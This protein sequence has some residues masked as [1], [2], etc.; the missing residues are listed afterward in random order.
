M[1]TFDRDVLPRRHP[2]SASA[3]IALAVSGTLFGGSALASLNHDARGDG[4][5]A[6][7]VQKATQLAAIETLR[8]E[9]PAAMATFDPMTGATRTLSSRV[10]YLSDGDPLRQ[11]PDG[12]MAWVEER[13]DLLGLT[14]EDLAEVEMTDRVVSRVT[15]ATHFYFRQ[16]HRGVP[17]YNG[18]LQIN[19]NRDGRILSVNNAF[20]PDLAA[21]VNALAAEIAPAQAVDALAASLSL[22]TEALETSADARLMFLPVGAGDTRLVWNFRAATADGASYFDANV[23]AL[24]G[25]LWT[26]FDWVASDSYRVYPQPAES[27]NHVAP[28]PPADGRS[29]VNNPADTTASPFG[30][31][32]TNGVAGAEFTITR[33]NNVHA[34]EDRNNNNNPPPVEVDCG[35][36]LDCDFPIDLT[37]QPNQYI[38]AAVTNLFYWNNVVHDVQYQYGFDEAAGNF[39]VNNYGNGGAGNDDVR[40][41]AQDGGG[42]NNANFLTLPDGNRPR[43]QMYLWAGNPQIDGDLDNGIIVHEYGHGISNRQVGGPG[44]TG[45]L[46]NLQQPGEGWSDWLALAYTAETGDQGTD[47]RGIGTYALGQGTGG[48]G[49]RT[50]RYSTDP[51]INTWLFSTIGTGVAVPHGVGAV[52]AQGNWEAYWALVDEHGFDPDLYDA[53]GGSG[54]QRAMLYVNEGMKNTAC[55]PTFLDARDGV[56]QAAT[57][58]YNG[59]DV[60]LL[61]N[62]YAAFGLGV[63]ATAV[64][65]NSLQVTDGFRVPEECGCETDLTIHNPTVRPGE[66]LDFTVSLHHRRVG[67]VEAAFTAR[68]ETLEGGHVLSR[69]AKPQTWRYGDQRS[70]DQSWR[71]PLE[72]PLGDYRLFVSIDQMRQGTVLAEQIF[73][74]VEN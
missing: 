68:I 7:A 27:P 61:W 15:G 16:L 4:V 58:N 31:H 69:T 2:A 14:P 66:L 37:Q 56:I 23:D 52:W 43:M 17:V 13:L 30:W 5:S 28:A 45:C 21:S 10:G 47:G 42:L 49:I 20:V 60:C 9:M 34:Y 55:S 64:G 73:T 1:Q 62:A 57:D 39:Q 41:Q 54:N 72:A 74:V 70:V 35:A 44:N 33:G 19:V 24:S 8:Q 12:A 29:L 22:P 53:N 71:I 18:Q 38:P 3:L 48:P 26:R 6:G 40:A 50:Q 59:E 32:D 63:D 36:A 65:P 25:R 51:A 46:S 11:T 67:E